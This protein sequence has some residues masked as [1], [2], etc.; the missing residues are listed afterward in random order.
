MYTFVQFIRIWKASFFYLLKKQN[1]S[2]NLFWS[3]FFPLHN[4][5]QFLPTSLPGCIISFSLSLKNKQEEKKANR[6][7]FKIINSKEKVQE[8]YTHKQNL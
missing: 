1:F 8:T 7:E 2:Y 4:V 6:P 3:Q 5:S